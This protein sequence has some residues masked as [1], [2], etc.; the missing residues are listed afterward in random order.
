MVFG[1]M[2]DDCGT[3]VA[4]TRNPATGVNE[5]YGEFLI[6]A[7]G[8]D[9]V[10]G[11]RTPESISQ[12]E[13]TLPEIYKQFVEVGELLEKNYRDV[14]DLEFT[15]ERG[16][17]YMLQTRSANRTPQ[18]AVKIAV[19]MA[20]EGLISKEEALL[21]VKP[22]QV[23]QLLLP[24]FD[25]KSKAKATRDGNLLTSGLNASPG[26]AFGRVIFSADKAEKMKDEIG[27]IILV[28]PETSPDDVHGMLVAKGVLTALGGATS[29]AAV[30]A[31]GL[32][33]PC[34]VGAGALIVNELQG[35]FS[36]NG[37]TIYENEE[38]S[39]DGSTGEV[40][41]GRIDT[42]EP[43]IEQEKDLQIL[44]Q[45]ADE[46]RRLGVW[47]NADTPQ[48]AQRGLDAG[49][50]GIGLCRTE[51]MF[52][53]EDRLPIMR[54]MILAAAEATALEERSASLRDQ[55]QNNLA[56]DGREEATA[57]LQQLEEEIKTSLAVAQYHESLA[58]LMHFQ[59]E[60]FR[61]ILNVMAGKP[62]IIRLLDPP[63]HEFLPNYESLLEQTVE[64]RIKQNNPGGLEESEKLLV[65]V[66]SM[67]EVNPMLGLRGCRLGLMYSAVNSMQVQAI[68]GA[69]CEL[70]TQGVDVLPEVMIPLVGHANEL[71]IVR[72][73][74]EKVAIQTQEDWK[75]QVHYKFGTMV[76]VPRAA[77]TADEIAQYADF[78]SFGTNDLTQTTFGYSR[79]DAESKF[80]LKYVE[81]GI[82]PRNPFQTL[83]TE[84]VGKLMQTAVTLGLQM[85]P[86]LE[87]GVCGEHGGD[88]ESIEFCHSLGLDYVSCSP[89]RVPV[90][91]LAAAQATIGGIL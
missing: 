34:V 21:R 62:V 88:P 32:G 19:D 77:L 5:L 79:D 83:D 57:Q 28:R 74:L 38:I 13:K 69:A 59:R 16:K 24:R 44:L 1:N 54:R 17:L 75:V 61:E 80:L 55:I 45:W 73:E 47:A 58:Q 46:K 30:V 11:I 78:F 90:A 22:N 53:A 91:R 35:Y 42:I 85:K 82:L 4:F 66:A 27:N 60:D 6:N 76:E 25:D 36:V 9:V 72:Q 48:D 64:L 51:H 71:M 7:Q 63:L 12:L 67:R 41:L 20:L 49:A 52:F 29:H 84:G 81:R 87:I 14:Q 3:G 2:G 18:A 65:A 8:E 39:I 50:E 70:A 40:F 33:L 31:R 86:D 37:L 43:V 26:A 23:E 56:R 89:F 68:F 15:V 10:A